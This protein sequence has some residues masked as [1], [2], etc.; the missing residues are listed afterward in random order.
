MTKSKPKLNTAIRAQLDVLSL[1]QKEFAHRQRIDHAVLRVQLTRNVYSGEVLTGA[2]Q[3]LCDG[4]RSELKE[5]YEFEET[6]RKRKSIVLPTQS[7]RE[8][9]G[10]T[11]RKRQASNLPHDIEVLYSA[12]RAS[13][14]VV[15]CTFDL[16]PLEC[17]APGWERL[18]A[19]LVRAVTNGTQFVYIRPTEAVRTQQSKLLPEF[20]SA[21]TPVQEIFD[22]QQ[23]LL[24]E[25]GSDEQANER[26]MS[27]VRLLEVDQCPFWSVGMRFGF[28]SV[29]SE[30]KDTRDMTLFARF[31]FGGRSEDSVDSKLLLF[32]DERTTDAFQSYLIRKFEEH[33]LPELIARLI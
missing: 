27:S 9:L 22:L 20:F 29:T 2:A 6:T 11:I 14:L 10:R 16:S 7:L 4:N 21:R 17:T 3:I 23:K 30:E 18:K 1:T 19:S 8:S 13:D 5:R 31:P 26:L 28:Y 24:N 25:M 12:L 33:K 32:A 15:I